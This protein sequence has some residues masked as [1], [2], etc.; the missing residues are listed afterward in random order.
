MAT[1]GNDFRSL[2]VAASLKVYCIIF[3]FNFFFIFPQPNGCGLIEG[4]VMICIY[5]MVIY[6]SAA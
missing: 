3:F 4:Y 2:T 1:G 6:I 5:I